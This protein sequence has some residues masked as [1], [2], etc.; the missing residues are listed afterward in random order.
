MDYAGEW[1]VKLYLRE[2]NDDRA[3]P[4]LARGLRD[5]LLRYAEPLAR[6]G[7]P[8]P[9][10]G[11]LMRGKSAE[12]CIEQLVNSMAAQPDE[13]DLVVAYIG[14]WIDAGWLTLKKQKSRHILCITNYLE[15]QTARTKAAERQRRYRQRL[16][17]RKESQKV[18]PTKP[19]VTRDERVRAA[20]VTNDVRIRERIRSDTYVPEGTGNVTRYADPAPDFDDQHERVCELASEYLADPVGVGLE[21]GEPHTWPPVVAVIEAGNRVWERKDRPQRSQDR[22]VQVILERLSDGL[23]APELIEAVEGS[24]HDDFVAREPRLQTVASLLKHPDRIETFRQ[25]AQSPP[26]PQP[27]G[28]RGRGGPQQ[29]EGD[30]DTGWTDKMTPSDEPDVKALAQ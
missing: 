4:V 7:D 17:K 28:G 20:L 19:T 29:P 24:R 26:E 25:L 14:T 10:T 27:P 13:R 22:R 9:R 3:K 12:H 5:N 18:T 6:N 1:W 16:A 8:T 23:T 11:E 2:S 15:A 30:Y 21:H